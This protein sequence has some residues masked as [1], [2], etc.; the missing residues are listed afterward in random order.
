MEK[1]E[2]EGEVAYG[3]V[4]NVPKSRWR[5]QAYLRI[6]AGPQ[7]DR[8]VH[9][10]VMEAI[11]GRELLPGETVD[12]EDGNTLNNRWTNLVLRDRAEHSRVEL[13]RRRERGHVTDDANTSGSDG[14][15][16]TR[17][18]GSSGADE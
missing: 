17:G 6:K 11:L 7:R 16:G 2:R 3:T 10:L 4:V 9:E 8:Y 5:R 1:K 15:A 13:A 14:E 18:V 12:H